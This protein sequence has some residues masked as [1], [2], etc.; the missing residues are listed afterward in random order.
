MLQC[1]KFNLNSNV[2]KKNSCIGC[3]NVHGAHVTANNSTNNNDV[4][5]FVS[6]LKIVYY[7]NY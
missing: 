6:E 4:L 5:F 1:T 2:E 3:L 7:N